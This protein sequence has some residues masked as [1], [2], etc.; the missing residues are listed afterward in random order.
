LSALVA[1]DA[2]H[3]GRSLDEVAGLAVNQIDRALAQVR[4]T[5]EA[6][7]LEV[8][9]VGRAGL[10]S[11]VIGLLVHAA[12]HTTRHVGQAITTAR[13]VASF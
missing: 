12:E 8:R 5:S 10:P 9:R 13:I 1:E 6:S 11:T 3:S 7:L 4:N 2:D